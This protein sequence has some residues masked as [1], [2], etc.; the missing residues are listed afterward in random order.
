M[1]LN[2]TADEE[3]IKRNNI[4]IFE[5]WVLRWTTRQIEYIACPEKNFTLEVQGLGLNVET[6]FHVCFIDISLKHIGVTGLNLTI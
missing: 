2:K 3:Q 5:K 1:L 4:F 6:K